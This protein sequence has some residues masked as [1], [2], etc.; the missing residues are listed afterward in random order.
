MS[1]CRCRRSYADNAVTLDE[2][3]GMVQGRGIVAIEQHAAHEGQALR[4]RGPRRLCV[5]ILHGRS[6]HHYG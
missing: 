3:G 2:D 6:Q 1:A 4:G 5:E